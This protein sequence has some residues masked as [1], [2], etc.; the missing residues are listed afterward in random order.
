MSARDHT[1][2]GLNRADP[3]ARD[4]PPPKKRANLDGGAPFN[5]ATETAEALRQIQERQATRKEKGE[6]PEVGRT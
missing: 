2:E 1:E 4:V 6:G 5:S 3:G